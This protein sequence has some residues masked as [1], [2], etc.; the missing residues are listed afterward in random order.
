MTALVV[1]IVVGTPAT[2]LVRPE[3]FREPGE[4][5]LIVE[6]DGSLQTEV[7]MIGFCLSVFRRIGP[8]SFIVGNDLFPGDAWNRRP[9][10]GCEA[11]GLMDAVI[12]LPASVRSG[13][14]MLCDY[15]SCH[16]LTASVSPQ[17]HIWPHVPQVSGI[18]SDSS[19]R[20]P[21]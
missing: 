3:R 16:R 14:W 7:A 8:V 2:I 15:V 5:L 1:L 12:N 11:V 20:P 13:D 9:F 21:R 4:D 10:N 18:S 17:G 6:V 19:R